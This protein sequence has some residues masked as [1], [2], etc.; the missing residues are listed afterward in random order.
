[1]SHVNC[2]NFGQGRESS[3][4]SPFFHLSQLLLESLLQKSVQLVFGRVALHDFGARRLAQPQRHPLGTA[5]EFL[6]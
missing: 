5:I 2:V 6:T 3:E 1:M 4:L